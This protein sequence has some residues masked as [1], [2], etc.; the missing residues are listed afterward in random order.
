[1]GFERRTVVVLAALGVVCAA[2][3]LAVDAGP[4]G[5]PEFVPAAGDPAREADAAP[6]PP[7]EPPATAAAPPA[8]EDPAAA[9]AE[10]LGMLLGPTDGA[11]AARTPGAAGRVRGYRESG[12]RILDERSRREFREAAW[13]ELAQEFIRPTSHLAG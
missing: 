5:L 6:S 8:A 10:G 7:A 4:A 9:I 3:A 12:L 1:M 13:K 2:W 11:A